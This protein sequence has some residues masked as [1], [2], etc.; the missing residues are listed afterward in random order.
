MCVLIHRFT[1]IYNDLQRCRQDFCFGKG[2]MINNLLVLQRE[3]AACMRNSGREYR[4]LRARR[5]LSQFRDVP[6]RTR[7][8][9]S[10]LCTLYS[11]SALL[12]LNGTSVNI[13]SALLALSW[14]YMLPS[15]AKR[16]AFSYQTE[17]ARK[18]WG[19]RIV[20]L[21]DYQLKNWETRILY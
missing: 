15:R 13:N 3:C 17:F 10:P 5:A 7:R 12:G 18:V 6:L 19:L 8:A 14:R 9:L 16:E 4:Q 21:L 2:G 1:T 20:S 11:D